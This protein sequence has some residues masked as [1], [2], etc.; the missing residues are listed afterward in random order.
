MGICQ[1][2]FAQ[3][4]GSDTYFPRLRYTLP[5]HEAIEHGLDMVQSL[6]ID[7]R[8]NTD[9]EGVVHDEICVCQIPR[10]AMGDVLICG[11]TQ[12]IAAEEVS[13]L[14][15]SGDTIPNSDQFGSCPQISRFMSPDFM[16]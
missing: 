8:I 14:V 6:V 4:W 11:M 15:K 9:E 1:E 2:S 3:T 12:E 7:S 16:V 5:S 13:G 10:N